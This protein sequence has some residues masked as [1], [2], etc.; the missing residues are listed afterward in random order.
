MLIYRTQKKSKTL[1][2]YLWI[3]NKRVIV[4]QPNVN[5]VIYW[6]H[7]NVKIRRRILVILSLLIRF[8]LFRNW[9]VN[10][11]IFLSVQCCLFGFI[12]KYQWFCLYLFVNSSLCFQYDCDLRLHFI[13][14]TV[15]SL[16][17]MCQLLTIWF[18]DQTKLN[19]HL[20]ALSLF[21]SRS[22]QFNV[23]S[24]RFH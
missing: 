19:I 6:I 15:W 24:N 7:R 23:R 14:E 13:L 17:S 5:V 9:I 10:R 3:F 12:L 20:S 8:V 22:E 11:L 1:K 2:V 18:R 21:L 16:L 4:Y